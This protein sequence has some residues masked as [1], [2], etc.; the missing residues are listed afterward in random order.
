MQRKNLDFLGGLKGHVATMQCV[1]GEQSK[2]E[3]KR[4]ADWYARPGEAV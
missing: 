3:T 4:E 2:V 1:R